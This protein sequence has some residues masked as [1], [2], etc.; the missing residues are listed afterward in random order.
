MSCQGLTTEQLTPCSA[1]IAARTSPSVKAVNAHVFSALLRS[2]Q[3]PLTAILGYADLA[4]DGAP[5][6]DDVRACLES[7]RSNGQRMYDLLAG[8]MA[9]AELDES[10]VAPDLTPWS[11]TELCRDAVAESR[12]WAE[13]LPVSITLE[14]APGV[15]E[16]IL[17]DPLRLRR[18][19]HVLL[20]R[21]MCCAPGSDLRVTIAPQAGCPCGR[22]ESTMIC[23]A[24]DGGLCLKPTEDVIGDN[25]ADALAESLGAR[26]ARSRSGSRCDLSVCLC[27]DG[28]EV[29]RVGYEDTWLIDGGERSSA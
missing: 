19:L 12:A 24:T 26:L 28:C 13:A 23:I 1:C 20:K 29:R 2:A 15:A 17:T 3:E 10:E 27:N 8:A 16:T 25:L 7:I 11:P 18:L 9:I 14:C 21:T 5:S 22:G 4:L 6:H